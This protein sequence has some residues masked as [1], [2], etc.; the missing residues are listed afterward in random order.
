MKKF[1]PSF[2]LTAGAISLLL[3][4][5]A[6]SNAPGA[7]QKCQVCHNGNQPHTVFIKC[8]KVPRYLQDHPGDYEGPCQGVS[9]EKPPKPS[10]SPKP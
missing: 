7:A 9:N 4:F 1:L 2:A 5:F 3:I 10:P 8:S 6:A